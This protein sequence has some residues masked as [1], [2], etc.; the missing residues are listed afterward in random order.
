MF[1]PDTLKLVEDDAV[2]DV[3]LNAVGVPVVEMMGVTTLKA[4]DADAVDV[5]PALSLAVP[6][7]IEIPNVPLPV[8]P[9][10]ATV[11]EV[12]EPDKPTV[13][14]AVPVWLSVILPGTSVL[15]LKFAS[16]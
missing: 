11:Y 5:F 7:A 14:L 15:V 3:V 10:M 1:E 4:V 16:A 12:P 9:E 6:A 8:M 2:P 13:P